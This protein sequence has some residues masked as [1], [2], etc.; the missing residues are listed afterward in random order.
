M[1]SNKLKIQASIAGFNGSPATLYALY[2]EKQNILVISKE[3]PFRSDR[4]SDCLVVSNVDV[5][6][7]DA[8][9]AP[10]DF[11]E[12]MGLFFEM[13]GFG[14][15]EISDAVARCNPMNQIEKDGVRESGKAAYNLAPDITN[16]QVAV[17][18][19]VWHVSKAKVISRGL[20]FQD[21]LLE[22]SLAD[23]LTGGGI[24]T[25]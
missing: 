22:L 2:D 6:D 13:T 10:E 20:D 23:E 14:S 18:S 15:I 8:F 19:I 16:G 12:A 4:F 24:M 11:N 21:K 1:T 25:I 5:D 17:L 7:R 9:F 3:V